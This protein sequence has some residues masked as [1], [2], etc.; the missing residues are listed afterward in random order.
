MSNQQNQTQP[1]DIAPEKILKH[2]QYFW[3]E[4]IGVGIC[5]VRVGLLDGKRAP[6]FE[7][8]QVDISTWCPSRTLVER[9][10]GLFLFTTDR[11][12]SFS[13]FVQAHHV[14]FGDEVQGK[15]TH[16]DKHG[17]ELVLSHAFGSED[18]L[19]DVRAV[20]SRS[21]Y[22]LNDDKSPIVP[23]MG[24]TL[25]GLIIDKVD[26][27]K[28]LV[29]VSLRPQTRRLAIVQKAFEQGH[30][31]QIVEIVRDHGDKSHSEFRLA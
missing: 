19:S 11:A 26:P 24:E 12:T 10:R 8:L 15:V 6:N 16:V 27:R 22:A 20:L 30:A 23:V 31:V 7:K 1:Q 2:Y 25:Q 3:G 9:D 18:Q 21:D 29:Y 28:K 17:T 14:G 5:T 4:V 13:H